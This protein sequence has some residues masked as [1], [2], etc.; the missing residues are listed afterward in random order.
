MIYQEF[1]PHPLLSPFIGAYWTAIGTSAD[2]TAHKILPD[3]CIDIIINLGS[4]SPAGAQSSLKY[5]QAYL[6]G[7]MTR[8]KYSVMLPG[9]HLLGVRFKPGGFGAFFNFGALH[10]LT[11]QTIELDKKLS[12]EISAWRSSLLKDLDSFFLSRLSEPKNPLTAAAE[13]ITR[14]QGRIR[15]AELAGLHCTTVRQLERSF[16]LSIGISPKELINISRCQFAIEKIRRKPLNQSLMQIAF[17]CGYYDHA[18]LS[19]EISK[20]TGEAP[21][22]I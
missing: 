16:R 6:V 1:P 3:G 17:D 21:S 4:D 14:C 12:P 9:S 20:Y 8:F 19:N 5:E 11:D 7:A 13:T 22:C 2:G 18:H 15:V 10:T